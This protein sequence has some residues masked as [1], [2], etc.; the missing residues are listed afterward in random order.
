MNSKRYACLLCPRK[1]EIMPPDIV[2]AMN[3]F[4]RVAD[5]AR[6]KCV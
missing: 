6:F 1:V 5:L 3:I 2:F 4:A